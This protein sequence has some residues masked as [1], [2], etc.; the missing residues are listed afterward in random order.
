[1]RAK[2]QQQAYSGR[3]VDAGFVP[4]A[5]GRPLDG[6][7]AYAASASTLAQKMLMRVMSYSP[8]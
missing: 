2:S 8:L 3:R 6:G 7:A 4:F 5:V 1:M